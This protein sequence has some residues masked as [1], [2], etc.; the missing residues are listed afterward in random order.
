MFGYR[1][2]STLEFQIYRTVVPVGKGRPTVLREVVVPACLPACLPALCFSSCFPLAF[3]C[4]RGCAE[5]RVSPQKGAKARSRSSRVAF[6][7]WW[8]GSRKM[9][10][11]N[12]PPYWWVGGFLF[13]PLNI[14]GIY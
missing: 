11:Q 8:V 5:S 12:P 6:R 2:I 7:N 14:R 1:R 3:A 9:V 10:G 13:S 4:R